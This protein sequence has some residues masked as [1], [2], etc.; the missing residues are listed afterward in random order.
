MDG[1]NWSETNRPAATL[2]GTECCWRRDFIS[3]NEN[4]ALNEQKSVQVVLPRPVRFTPVLTVHRRRGALQNRPA[5]PK[6]P[7]V[8]HWIANS[9]ANVYKRV[10]TYVVN[11]TGSLS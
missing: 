1:Q 9:P 6:L 7:S 10:L 5:D 4:L 8:L 2:L 3:G 11:I